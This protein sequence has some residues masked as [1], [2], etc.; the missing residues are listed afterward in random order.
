MLAIVTDEFGVCKMQTFNFY[1][2]TLK[3]N[4]KLT[5]ETQLNFNVASGESVQSYLHWT[6]KLSVHGGRKPLLQKYLFY[7][8]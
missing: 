4:P 5:A 1:I 6:D 7:S 2:W 3:Y 8:Q